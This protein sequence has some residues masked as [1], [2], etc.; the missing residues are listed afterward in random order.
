MLS[1]AVLVSR[2]GNFFAARRKQWTCGKHCCTAELRLNG[3]A[4]VLQDMKAVGDLL[5]AARPRVRLG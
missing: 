5:P 1:A 3:I 2:A 4:Q